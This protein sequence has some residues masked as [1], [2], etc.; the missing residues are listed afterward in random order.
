M[1]ELG[2][3]SAPKKRRCSVTIPSPAE[4]YLKGVMIS[5][6]T[7]FRKVAQRGPQGLARPPGAQT[8]R[9]SRRPFITFLLAKKQPAKINEPG[10]QTKETNERK[11]LKQNLK[12]QKKEQWKP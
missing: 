5:F 10:P 8:D 9:A 3:I 7:W 12:S 6:E 11:L 1:V 4:L 2:E